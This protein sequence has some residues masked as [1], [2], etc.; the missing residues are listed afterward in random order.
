MAS[1]SGSAVNMSLDEFANEVREYLRD[2]PELNKLIE[3]QGGWENTIPQIRRCVRM[4]IDDFNI[5]PPHVISCSDIRAFPSYGLLMHGT[6]IEV[7]RTVG[8]YS[9]RNQLP[10]NDGGINVQLYAKAGPYASWANNLYNVY[11][12]NKI[13]YK[14]AKNAEF[15]YGSHTSEYYDIPDYSY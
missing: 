3:E 4:A 6:V 13:K 10:Y 1:F 7:L 15:A 11:Q 8:I 2:D 12:S 9:V 5:T 14:I